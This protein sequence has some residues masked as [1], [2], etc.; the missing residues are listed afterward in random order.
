VGAASSVGSRGDSYD[1][2]AES[3]MGLYN[4]ELITM[5]APWRTVEDVELATLPWMY[6]WNK[7]RLHSAIGDLPPAEFEARQGPTTAA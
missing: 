6:R 3:V 5:Q 7:H 2:R 1:A 4:T